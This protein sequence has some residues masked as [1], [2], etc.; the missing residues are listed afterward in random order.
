MIRLAVLILVLL[1]SS[2]AVAVTRYVSVTGTGS[3]G[4][5]T[6]TEAAAC[7][8]NIALGIVNAGD[9]IVM[10]DGEYKGTTRMLIPYSGQAARP[11]TAAQRITVQA[12][13]DGKVLINGEKAR[14]PIGLYKG[15]NYWTIK[16]INACCALDTTVMIGDQNNN[17]RLER[18]IAWDQEDATA[19]VMTVWGTQNTTLVDVAAFGHGRKMLAVI[20]DTNTV[21]NR[22]LFFKFKTR[23]AP[24]N[25]GVTTTYAYKSNGNRFYNTINGTDLVAPTIP[26]YYQNAIF[27]VDHYQDQHGKNITLGVHGNITY[28]VDG[29]AVGGMNYLSTYA[30][31]YS[32]NLPTDNSI[33]MTARNNLDMR[34]NAAIPPDGGGYRC[35]PATGAPGYSLTCFED[36]WTDSLGSLASGT[37]STEGGNI[38]AS[39]AP[40]L[41]RLASTTQPASGAWIRY[42]YTDAG[43]L[44]T[45]ELWNPWPMNARVKAAIEGTE[46][47][48]RGWDGK[49]NT[50]ITAVVLA[51]A[52]SSLGPTAVLHLAYTTQPQS[53]LLGA[54][55]PSVRACVYNA[56]NVVQLGHA[57]NL[58]IALENNP[59]GA[60]LGGTLTQAPVSGCATWNNLTVSAAGNGY[61]LQVTSSGVTEADSTPFNITTAPVTV[62]GNR[63]RY[64]P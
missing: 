21:V 24:N 53:V 59:S 38:T 42:K 26:G 41:L 52:G 4:C 63:V 22:G 61:T 16:G 17:N 28:H 64:I 31:S 35:A 33:A 6:N 55:L 2:T 39:A 49:G 47:K 7:Q 43:A 5:T 45:D 36:N 10:K 50:D 27:S 62:V 29:Q 15:V 46:Y 37:H 23:D 8:L 3:T 34:R 51:L 12:E 60:T 20:T 25:A 40:D 1:W 9:I 44:T 32:G 58:T 18:V 54:T 56:D 48:N 30:F 13:N 19:G 14:R 57:A 11:G